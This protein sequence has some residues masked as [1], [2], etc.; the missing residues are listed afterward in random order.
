MSLVEPDSTPA[1]RSSCSSLSSGRNRRVID[2]S[3]TPES[4]IGIAVIGDVELQFV[5]AFGSGIAYERD[6]F[7]EGV[8]AVA[9]RVATGEPDD[10]GPLRGD[11][12]QA[13]A[14]AC[15]QDRHVGSVLAQVLDDVPKVVDA[16]SC[17]REGN[18]GGLE[19]LLDVA[20][21][22]PEFEAS[23]AEIPQCLDVAG[24]QRRL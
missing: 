19:L 13:V 8:A 18:L 4:S 6:S 24:Q 10:V 3:G 7:G 16:L 11:R 5:E 2:R 1:V 22:E 20:G 17:R 14:I 9:G 15:D 21:A 23:A 12:Q